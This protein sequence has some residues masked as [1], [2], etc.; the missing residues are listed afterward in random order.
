MKPEEPM[1]KNTGEKKLETPIH[2]FRKPPAAS[3][4]ERVLSMRDRNLIVGACVTYCGQAGNRKI[5]E[6]VYLERVKRLLRFDETVEYLAMINDAIYDA[7]LAWEGTRNKYKAWLSV[8]EG[9]LKA[10]DI[11]KEYPNFVLNAE[12]LKP[13]ALPPKVKPEDLVGPESTFQVP[14]K[15]DA[16]ISDALSEMEWPT[17]RT[18]MTEGAA[19]LARKFDMADKE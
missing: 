15:L 4:V 8:K 12:P 3:C 13:S 18:D 14:A 17:E 10:S 11:L 2:A 5:K 19:E 6:Q 16:W 7:K 9:A 1:L